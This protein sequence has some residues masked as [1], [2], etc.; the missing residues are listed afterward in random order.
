[1]NYNPV[2]GRFTQEDPCCGDGLNLYA[3]C[4]NNPVAD[5]RGTGALSWT[6][7]GTFDGSKGYYELINNRSQ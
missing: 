5:P 2:I 3:Y 7:E 4:A 1:M 6:V